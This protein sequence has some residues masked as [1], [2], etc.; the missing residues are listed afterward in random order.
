MR[1]DIV[2]NYIT[3]NGDT[4]DLIAF[5]V[6]GKLANIEE[7][8]S[9]NPDFIKIAKFPADTILIIPPLKEEIG[10]TPEWY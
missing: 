3:T 1:R 2:S 9:C 4:W 5:K 8:K 10:G 6:Y 7:L